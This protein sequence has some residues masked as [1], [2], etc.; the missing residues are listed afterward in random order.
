MT[1]SRRFFPAL[2]ALVAG[3]LTCV[4]GATPASAAP[5]PISLIPGL[6]AVNVHSGKCLVV[7]G[8][9]DLV[10]QRSCAQDPAFRWRPIPVSLFG[11]FH[12]ENEKSGKCLTISGG[13][14]EDG[15]LVMQYACDAQESR[16]WSF[17]D[18]PGKGVYVENVNSGKCLTVAGGGIG[19]NGQI[20]QY[21]CDGEVSRRWSF[22]LTPDG[23]GV[24]TVNG[25]RP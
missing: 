20:V 24:V 13:G 9:S 5:R 8:D 14:R 23:P 17:A 16:A 10:V 12:L 1:F 15:G 21:R 2:P 4:A 22:R 18:A 3:A 6:L 19:E 11:W 25:G 7:A